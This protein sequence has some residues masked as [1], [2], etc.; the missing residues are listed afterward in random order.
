M[1]LAFHQ[2]DP[3]TFKK[4]LKLNQQYWGRIKLSD[5]LGVGTSE[6]IEKKKCMVV[7][8]GG[9]GEITKRLEVRKETRRKEIRGEKRRKEM[10]EKECREGRRERGMKEGWKEGK[11]EGK[12]ERKQKAKRKNEGEGGRREAREM[13]EEKAQ[14]LG[15]GREGKM[16]WIE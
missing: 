11:K 12:K 5:K 6:G 16:W 4:V 13:R 3:L 1:T 7:G 14:K 15:I 2:E 8:N 9:E 10:R